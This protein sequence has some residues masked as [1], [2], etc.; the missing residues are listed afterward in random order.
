MGNSP[1]IDAKTFEWV[2]RLEKNSDVIKQELVA[3]LGAQKHLPNIRELS[4]RQTNL[5][6]DDGWKSYFFS[7]LVIGSTRAT[8]VV[9]RRANS[10]NFISGAGACILFGACAW[11]AHQAPSWKLQGCAQVSSWIDRTGAAGAACPYA[12]R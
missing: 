4:P 3:L 1:V 9:Q 12:G 2:E 7:S 11:N 8:T 10:L 6:R 5:S